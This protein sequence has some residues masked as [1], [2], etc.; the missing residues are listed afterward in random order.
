M[1]SLE[2]SEQ[3]YFP[4]RNFIF[5]L[6]HRRVS[7]TVQNYVTL[8]IPGRSQIKYLWTNAE[9]WIIF[10]LRHRIGWCPEPT[11]LSGIW[12][13]R[14]GEETRLSWDL[15][16][17]FRERERLRSEQQNWEEPTRRRREW[18]PWEVHDYLFKL[19]VLKLGV[20]TLLKVTI[21][22]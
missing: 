10:T 2:G 4:V 21:F 19:A 17:R 7:T 18:W 11:H 1:N 3:N 5:T 8:Y 22:F 6:R 12:S 15:P 20:K 13:I 16:G 14:P 9:L